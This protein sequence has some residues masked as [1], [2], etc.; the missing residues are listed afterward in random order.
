[1]ITI[2]FHRK[3][4]CMGDDAGNGEYTIQMPDAATLGDLMH[5]ILRGGN[6]NGWP[7][8]YTGARLSGKITAEV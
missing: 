4:V 3:S 7:I 5:V 1:M 2:S 8:P 6:G